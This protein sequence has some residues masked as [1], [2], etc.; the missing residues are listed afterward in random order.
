MNADQ[1]CVHPRNL[2]QRLHRDWS[3]LF[4]MGSFDKFLTKVFGSSN[5]RFLKSIGPIV[6]NIN[7]LEPSVKALSDDELRGRTAVFKE[8][9]Q[10]V[11]GDTTD[12]DERKRLERVALDELLPEAF[13]VVREASVR[14]TGMRHFDVQLIGGM[15]LHQGK[16]AEM[17]TGEGK[18]LVAT[19]P[20][21]LNA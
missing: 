21:Y 14:T 12:K 6:E 16:I 5:Q 4:S 19:L 2:R 20:S 10:S 3:Q 15:V 1:S 7:S 8:R 18:T 11:V 9:V 13:A 17:R